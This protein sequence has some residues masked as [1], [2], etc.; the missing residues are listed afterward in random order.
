ME[1][2][3]TPPE[4]SVFFVE[5]RHTWFERRKRNLMNEVRWRSAAGPL[6]RALK[7]QVHDD[8]K[9][10]ELLEDKVVSFGGGSTLRVRGLRV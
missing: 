9:V 3:N 8:P 2:A 7:A 1:L 10:E 5:E 4:H 6:R